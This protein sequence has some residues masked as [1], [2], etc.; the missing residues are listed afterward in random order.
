M[1]SSAVLIVNTNQYESKLYFTENLAKALNNQGVN[2]LI[3]RL[4][5][6]KWTPDVY[7]EIKLFNPDFTCSY[8]SFLSMT[9][10]YPWDMLQIPHLEML[11]DPAFYAADFVR[12]PYVI[13]S[14][15]DKQDCRWFQDNHF[16]KIFFWPHAVEKMGPLTPSS[17][18]YDV[19]FLGTFIDF[20][21][22][23]F[24]W[25]KDLP[26]EQSQLI[27]EAAAIVLSDNKTSLV[28]ALADTWNKS[29]L[30][31]A[32]ADF[33]KLFYYLDNYTRGKD[34]FELIHAIKDVKVHVFGEPSW[35]NPFESASWATYLGSNPNIV[36]HPPVSYAE[37]FD[38]MRQSK[39]CLNSMPFF[40][41]G[42]HERIFNAL[43][44]GALPLTMDNLFVR[45]AFEIDQEL[46]VYT[47]GQWEKANEQV[48]TYLNNEGLR[49]A[50]VEKGFKKVMQQHTWD[51]RAKE[52]LE[53]LPKM[54]ATMLPVD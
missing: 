1:I 53:T 29:K 14:S 21:G 22:L 41:Y 44:C 54:M 34:R 26:P 37:S 49:E 27:L 43:A 42:S 2:T 12:S 31:P 39:I 50:L 6:G 28:Q 40:K 18:P 13:L 9:G 36:I 5:R 11:L 24:V 4:E 35:N 10:L 51:N 3:V 20:E 38:V 48:K 33:K 16:K 46:I 8:N 17:R 47:P 30:D 19:A 7:R 23:K 32:T 15:V 52:L 45:E 25:Q